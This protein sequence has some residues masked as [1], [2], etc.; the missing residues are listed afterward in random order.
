[1]GPAT[2][3]NA[4]DRWE[5][6]LAERF[7]LETPVRHAVLNEGIGGNTAV[8][9]PNFNPPRQFAVGRGPV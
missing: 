7:A 8:N 2:T 4:H 9:A 3:P 1:M 5:D 6:V